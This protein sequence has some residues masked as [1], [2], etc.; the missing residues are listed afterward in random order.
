MKQL[1]TLILL[2]ASVFF[3]GC[4][5]EDLS[6][7]LPD[8]NLTLAF[9]SLNFSD[10]ISR[11]TVAIYDQNGKLAETVQVEKADLDAFQ[12]VRLYL[13]AGDYT[14]VCWANAFDN[15][16]INGLSMGAGLNEQEVAHPG[17]F[18]SAR[19]P[20]NDALYYGIHTFTVKQDAASSETVAFTPAYIRFV[21][22]IKGLASTA[23]SEPS[24]G[25]PYIRV[26][27]LVPAYDYNMV[28]HGSPTTYYPP[29]TVDTGNK[30]AQAL[31]N[32]LR[33]GAVNP[34]TIDVLDNSTDNTVLHT[35]NLQQFIEDNN[36]VIADGKEVT[37][38]VLISFEGNTVIVTPIDNWGN[39]PVS[40]GKL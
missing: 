17:Y 6:D 4:I 1:K 18:N 23:K 20:T 31:C 16:Q 38:P 3:T 7:C 21:I 15:T 8:Q 2:V 9:T 32:V 22:Q 14:A 29:L 13:P 5:G 28:T 36:I 24:S 25:Y 27:N 30:L 12:G 26:N 34:V 39:I 10:K 11:V 40:P 33:F 19:I 37:I 35:V